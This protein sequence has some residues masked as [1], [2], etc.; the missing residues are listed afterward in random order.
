MPS[1]SQRT[2]LEPVLQIQTSTLARRSSEA[3][4]QGPL[5]V[6]G[7]QVAK[8]TATHLWSSSHQYR[9]HLTW[10]KPV[11]FTA[12][13]F[14][15]RSPRT[16]SGRRLE[17]CLSTMPQKHRASWKGLGPRCLDVDEI[18]APAVSSLGGLCLPESCEQGKSQQRMHR[19]SCWLLPAEDG[20]RF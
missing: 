14:P 16:V 1:T 18:L 3:L 20:R 11:G 2:D 19:P 9:N 13:V 15:G 4:N 8:Q 12:L 7:C 5:K 17:G 6:D 10:C